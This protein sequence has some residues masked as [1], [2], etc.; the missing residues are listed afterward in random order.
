AGGHTSVASDVD[1]VMILLGL[2][3]VGVRRHIANFV[4]LQ[5]ARDEIRRLAVDEERLRLARDLHDELG[6]T[7][8]TVVLQSELVS[9]ELPPDTSESTRRRLRQVM[10]SARSALQ[11]M[12]ELVTGFRQ[13]T[14]SQEVAS[15]GV[16]LEAAGIR[17]EVASP[18]L[19]LPQPTEA[20]LAWAVRE[21]ATNVLRH[22][23][24]TRCTISIAA[25]DGHVRL[26][27]RDDGRGSEVVDPGQGLRGVRERIEPLG[28]RLSTE[29]LTG[30]G[31]QRT[32]DIPIQQRFACS[33]PR[34]RRSCARRWRI[35]LP[36]TKTSA[37]WLRLAAA[38]K[39][40]P[41][42]YRQGQT[43]RCSTSNCPA[44]MGLRRRANCTIAC[45]AAI[46]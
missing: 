18:K 10:D 41:P 30:D 38:T 26:T 13:P 6:Q 23:R 9:L 11:S 19:E 27:V 29:D 15:A 5:L 36:A 46:F 37:L 4:Q 35:S 3:A 20:A 40:W 1:V 44:G 14:L 8:S 22:S 24:A 43:L 25:Q 32:V 39:F 33:L 12:R 7:L 2:G 17:C 34:I 31:F 16:T 21:G 42:L 45:Q 28:G